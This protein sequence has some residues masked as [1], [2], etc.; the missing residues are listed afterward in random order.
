MNLKTWF[1]ES[2]MR[3]SGIPIRKHMLFGLKPVYLVTDEEL[4]RFES[5]NDRRWTLV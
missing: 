3:A 2:M 5:Y 1:T 4:D